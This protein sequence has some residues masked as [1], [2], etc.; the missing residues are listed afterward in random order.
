M[1]E[2]T[3]LLDQLGGSYMVFLYLICSMKVVRE[4]REEVSGKN[5]KGIVLKQN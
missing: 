3:G 5:S 4:D 2:L 1:A